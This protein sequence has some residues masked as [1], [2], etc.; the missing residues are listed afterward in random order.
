MS[1]KSDS[2]S[3]RAKITRILV[4]GGRDYNQWLPF[5]QVMEQIASERFLRTKPDKY[6]NYLYQ[7]TIIHGGAR[8]ADRMAGDWADENWIQSK[9]YP[10]DWERYGRRAGYL[11]NK[12]MLEEGKPDLVIAFPGGEG[13]KMMVTL[14]KAAKVEVIEV[15]EILP[16]PEEV[17]DN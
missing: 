5:R 6:G 9:E 16:S 1:S 13:T 8:G 12:Q 15:T 14:A 2:T 3:T 17:R 7:V 10:A 11:R 4:C